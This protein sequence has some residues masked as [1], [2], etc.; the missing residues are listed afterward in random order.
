MPHIIVEYTNNLATVIE[1]D[2]LLPALHAVLL[3]K[4]D[5]FPIGG[6]RSRAIALEHFYVADGA[7]SDDAFVHL[8]LKI[9]GGRTK[10][11]KDETCS[12][13][14]TVLTNHFEKTFKERG[15][16]LS[17]ELNEFGAGGTLKK[18]TIHARYK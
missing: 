2:K 12:A 4:P 15:L 10:A 1:P 14:F 17:L 13:L 7:N 11:E 9:G 5:I 16:A 8:T 18:N 6:I 3:A